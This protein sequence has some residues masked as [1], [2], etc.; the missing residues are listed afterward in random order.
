MLPSGT[1][2][3]CKHF[4]LFF[5]SFLLFTCLC[6]TLLFVLFVFGPVFS[7]GR[8]SS[9][10]AIDGNLHELPFKGSCSRLLQNTNLHET[11]LKISLPSGITD[12][13]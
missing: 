4:M 9:I 13:R 10:A 12:R 2:G 5:L 6:L 8:Q 3:I 7:L 1:E 11:G